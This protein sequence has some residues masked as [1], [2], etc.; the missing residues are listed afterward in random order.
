MKKGSIDF[1][2][3]IYWVIALLIIFII[4]GLYIFLGDKGENYTSFFKNLVR[5]GKG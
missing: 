1:N 2:E 3:I 5:F 4:G